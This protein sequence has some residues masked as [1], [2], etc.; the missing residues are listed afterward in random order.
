MNYDE[1]QGFFLFIYFNKGE[2][3]QVMRRACAIKRI[4]SNIK[5]I[6]RYRT[7]KQFSMYPWQLGTFLISLST[8]GARIIL[9]LCSSMFTGFF[10]WWLTGGSVVT[11]ASYL[12]VIPTRATWARFLVLTCSDLGLD[13]ILYHL[14]AREGGRGG[15]NVL[16][17]AAGDPLFFPRWHSDGVLLLSESF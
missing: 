4:P 12:E 16:C 17:G 7:S 15:Q 1:F 5:Y 13:C 2:T 8:P 9:C 10:L 6:T 3:P 11:D 14:W